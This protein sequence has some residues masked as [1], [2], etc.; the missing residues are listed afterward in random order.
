MKKYILIAEIN[1]LRIPCSLELI[2]NQSIYY[3]YPYDVNKRI[4]SLK[5]KLQNIDDYFIEYRND[6]IKNSQVII[7]DDKSKILIIIE[8]QEVDDSIEKKSFDDLTDYF[9]II[10]KALNLFYTNIFNVGRISIFKK[11]IS[12]LKLIRIIENY[13]DIET[14]S[15]IG[16]ELLENKDVRYFEPFYQGILE[17]LLKNQKYTEVFDEYVY[18]KN[19]EKLEY[20]IVYLWNTLEHISEKFLKI[21]KRHRLILPEKFDE[22]KD[23]IEKKIGELSP[24]ELVFS[25]SVEVAKNIILEKIDNYPKILDKIFYLLKNYALFSNDIEDIVRY[26]YY[27]RNQIFHY[28][29]YFPKLLFKFQNNFLEKK[30]STIED[31]KKLI[32][33]FENL[34]NKILINIFELNELLEIKENNKLDWKKQF[35]QD[36]SY[37]NFLFTSSNGNRIEQIHDLQLLNF[38]SKNQLESYIQKTIGYLTRKDK[39]LRLL[40]FYSKT[41]TYWKKIFSLGY[42]KS[43]I[44]EFEDELLLKFENDKKGNYIVSRNSNFM[45]NLRNL[46][47]SG[48]QSRNISLTSYIYI[49]NIGTIQLKLQLINLVEDLRHIKETKGEFYCNQIDFGYG[50]FKKYGHRKL[51]LKSNCNNCN[52][53]IKEIG[54]INP[55]LFNELFF[56]INTIYYCEKCNYYSSQNLYIYPTIP[57][58]LVQIPIIIMEEEKIVRKGTGF[59]YIRLKNKKEH[60]FLITTYK[61]L[62][63]CFPNED[64]SKSGD[65][66]KLILH[67]SRENLNKSVKL[68]IP[69]HTKDNLPVWIQSEEQSNNDFVIL[70][71]FTQIFRHCEIKALSKRNMEIPSNLFSTL[72]LNVIGFKDGIFNEK[73]L[74]QIMCFPLSKQQLNNLI[75][76]SSQSIQPFHGMEG[77]PVFVT[78][79][80]FKEAIF[81]TIFIGI[82]SSFNNGIILKSDLIIDLID[83][84]DI[85][86]YISKI[87][88]NLPYTHQIDF[89]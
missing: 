8:I 44:D 26:V 80:N 6:P 87:F 36:K 84:I 43:F 54:I 50:Q 51:R 2:V 55:S 72:L 3:L 76:Q 30:N 21:K 7:K 57:E 85:N 79:N 88:S 58:Q 32:E 9:S 53:V 64:L 61:L 62:T 14:Y 20:K 74:P 39:Y 45:I 35:P 42:I 38:N 81:Q 56:F 24:T 89:Y 78:N 25:D 46:L 10:L 70:P 5:S 48:L 66:V 1:N 69:L 75:T 67:T 18:A 17:N 34:I 83:K 28:G 4:I 11:K 29:I 19:E 15:S 60:L 22:L 16:N 68:T 13:P 27:L 33:D 23:I 47:I 40:K 49:I 59:F 73:G 77:S 37:F 82:Y 71:I 65:K 52:K 63:G 86:N 31:L 12:I 41:L